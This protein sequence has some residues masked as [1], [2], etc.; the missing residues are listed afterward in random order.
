M[1]SVENLT[2]T[3]PTGTGPA[4]HGVS[5]EVPEGQFVALI[6]PNGAGKSTLCY[7]LSGF[8]PHFYNGDLAGQVEVAGHDVPKTGLGDLAGEVGL[9][10]SNPFNQITG[11]CYTVREEV[12]FGLE[13]LGIPREEMIP[14]VEEAIALA[15]LEGLGDRS[16]YALSGGQQQR[17]AIASVIV[18]RPRVLILDEP[19]SQLD[20]VGSR[21]VFELLDN[22]SRKG[23]STV[24]LVEQ[25]LEWIAV[26][27]DR[28]IALAG[29]QIVADGKPREVLT[30]PEVEQAGAGS[31]RYTQAARTAQARGSASKGET[32][33]VTLEQAAEFFAS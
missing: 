9:V 22:L 26:H 28:V 30:L 7:A 19:T 12:A 8:V 17:L 31:T 23:G 29:G 4:L 10:F 2:Y 27:A 14:R 1:I 11:A 24:V 21:E 20:P 33:P 15:G 6:G 32:L 13:N 3:Y 5:F 16:P 25:K 18:M